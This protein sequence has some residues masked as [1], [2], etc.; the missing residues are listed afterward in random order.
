MKGNASGWRQ[1]LKSAL[2]CL[3]I[4]AG[5]GRS[6]LA[7]EQLFDLALGE[8]MQLK[9]ST[10]SIHPASQREQ[11][12]IVTV[13]TAQDMAAAG[14]R[15]LQDA[16][17]LI[18]GVSFGIDVF[19]VPGLM[20]RGTW[21]YEGKILFLVDDIP[22]NDL[23]FG[24]YAIPP[25]FPVELLQRVEVLRGPGGAK[26]GEN[27]EL[28]VIR[29]YTRNSAP[30]DGFAALTL[31]AQHDGSPLR[32]FS[33]GQQ[34]RGGQGSLAV[35]GT[36]AAGSWGSGRWRDAQGSSVDVSTQ[37]VE[38]AQLAL[39][40]RWRSTRL[41]FYFEQFDL[42]A[43]QRYGIAV[44][45]QRM[46]F[47]HGNIR[48]E[49]DFHPAPATTL[50][51]RWTFR[52][53]NTWHGVSRELPAFYELPAQ[54][55][56]LE[57]EARH[58]FNSGVSARAGL[59]Q[60]WARVR[61]EELFVPD[62][63]PG[64]MP[65]EYFDG[66][67]EA[68]YHSFSAYAEADIPWRNYLLSVGGRYTDHSESGSAALPRLALTWTEP[69]WHLKGI[70]GTAYREP[71]FET[72]NQRAETLQPEYTTV[73]ELEAGRKLGAHQYLTGSLFQYRLRDA[74]VFS[75]APDGTPGYINAPVLHGRGLELQW[76]LH[77]ERWRL[78]ANFQRSWTDD[79]AI[80][81]YDVQGRRGQS[82]GAPRDVFNVWLGWQAT[83]AWSLHSRLR[84]QGARTALVFDAAS[85]A[86]PP[87]SQGRLDAELSLD[88]SARYR[89]SAWTVDM[90][91]KNLNDEE[92][93][94][95][96]PYTG[97]SPPYP[98]GS[99]EAWLRLQYDF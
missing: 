34:W 97:I 20:F 83:P 71:Q 45:D 21:A 81:I 56:T 12:G 51:S 53:E 95:P 61:A 68:D 32:Q 13:F 47:R 89:L 92:R 76:Q 59:Q 41:Q 90:G 24:T 27:A 16:L 8:L 54:R 57:L 9:V 67:R 87:L 11:P 31:A 94:L 30:R 10:A 58:A 36:A 2:L 1:P 37:D 66:R 91:I 72:S 29:I 50:T 86:D 55:H 69:D 85:L 75:V 82:L 42:D 5:A 26:Y 33:A 35:L 62:A 48:L 3:G 80:S 22:V 64:V 46:N 70:V 96:Q 4:A 7:Q 52:D 40:S 93:L 25:N 98:D 77:Y 19:N 88:L 39:S 63:F 28:A 73:Y 78:Q 6:A 15:T 74:I 84:Y 43:I 14:A 18:P 17:L 38:S 60:Y 65:D 49:H 79:D 23:L 99:R 44:P